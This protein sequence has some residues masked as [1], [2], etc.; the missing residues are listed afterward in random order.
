MVLLIFSNQ[1]PAFSITIPLHLS[2]NMWGACGFDF[3]FGINFIN[4]RKMFRLQFFDIL[5]QL[6]GK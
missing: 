1:C 6:L 5:L 4:F 3:G 2:K